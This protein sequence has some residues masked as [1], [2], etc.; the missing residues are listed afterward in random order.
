M[1]E[2]PLKINP[3]RFGVAELYTRDFAKLSSEEL[4][5]LVSIPHAE[6][7]CRFRGAQCNKKGGVCTLRAYEKREII[8]PV[9]GPLITVCPQRFFEDGEVY[10]WIGETLLGSPQFCVATEVD[11]LQGETQAADE[12]GE[13]V[14]RID[15]ILLRPDTVPLVWC[16]VEFQ[17]V[18]FS[19][20]GMST[21]FK[22]FAQWHGPGI[23]FPNEVRRPDYRSSGPKRLMPQLQVKIP[24]LRRWGKKMAV[25][26]DLSFFQHMGRMDEARDISNCD[27]VWFVVDHD[28]NP[29]GFKLVKRDLHLI[30]LERAIEGLIAGEAVSLTEFERRMMARLAKAQARRGRAR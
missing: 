2:R 1:N 28:P 19:G 13:P 3:K 29:E 23:P 21:Q 11:F 14:G 27:I 12:E 24:T 25:V 16:A 20:K 7:F 22:E 30:T 15:T 8:A 9:V 18:Y 5:R 10:R 6:H 26:T 4:R 17:A